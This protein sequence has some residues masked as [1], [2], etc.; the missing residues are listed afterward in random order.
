MNLDKTFSG[1]KSPCLVPHSTQE[2]RGRG[3]WEHSGLG[4]ESSCAPQKQAKDLDFLLLLLTLPANFL[5]AGQPFK[6]DDTYMNKS[7]FFLCF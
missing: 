3:K 5:F 6:A 1:Y 7:T 4:L 2:V